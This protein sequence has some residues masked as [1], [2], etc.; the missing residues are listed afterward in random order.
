MLRKIKALTQMVEA[1][2]QRYRKALEE[3]WHT[4]DL[5]SKGAE[6]ILRRIDAI[7]GQ[8][9]EARRQAHERIIAGRLV[10]NA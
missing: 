4:T 9:P 1:H 8:L 2:A 3:E 6:V 10:P 7:L 5:S